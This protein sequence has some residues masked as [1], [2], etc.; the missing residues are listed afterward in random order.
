[1]GLLS[2]TCPACGAGGQ[3]V[4]ALK[5]LSRSCALACS[6]CDAPLYS[7]ISWGRYLIFTLYGQLV[8]IGLGVPLVISLA[9]GK[10]LGAAL[11]FVIVAALLILP[12]MILHARE[13]RTRFNL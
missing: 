12:A 2:G 1:M 13:I 9:A 5:S 6:R 4:S 8:A 11:L 3:S 10:W 7:D